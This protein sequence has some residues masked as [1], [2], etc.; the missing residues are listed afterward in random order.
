[1]VHWQI[2]KCCVIAF[3]AYE[4][5]DVELHIADHKTILRCP[6]LNSAWR[7][8]TNRPGQCRRKFVHKN[9]PASCSQSLGD[10]MRWRQHLQEEEYQRG[11][12]EA[13]Y[14]GLCRAKTVRSC[15]ARLVHNLCMHLYFVD[16][17][18]LSTPL[19]YSTP[20]FCRCLYFVDTNILLTP[21][22]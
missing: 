1:M 20:I 14:C 22:F 3:C 18:I 19:F 7:A 10:C 11:Q 4:S 8:R 15:S 21:I 16:A 5:E 17:N 13:S 2:W 6:P 9:W 12:G